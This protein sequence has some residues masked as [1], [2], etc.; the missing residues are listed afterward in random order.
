MPGGPPGQ[1]P[2][3]GAGPP[4]GPPGQPPMHPG[5]Q[6]F[7]GQGNRPFPTHA[8]VPPSGAQPAP[9]GAQAPVGQ[10]GQPPANQSVPNHQVQQPPPQHAPP[11]QGIFLVIWF[12]IRK[13]I[14]HC[15]NFL[16]L[17]FSSTI[18]NCT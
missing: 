13:T 12:T 18:I 1:P 17:Y 7:M 16:K 3:G 10:P 5:Q 6:P 9:G 15:E 8:G 4:R 2:V 11:P 14:I